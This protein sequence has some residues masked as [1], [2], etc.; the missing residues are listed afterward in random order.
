MFSHADSIRRIRCGYLLLAPVFVV[1]VFVGQRVWVARRP[2]GPSHRIK[3]VV[4]YASDK[5]RA[6]LGPVGE[7]VSEPQAWRW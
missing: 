3:G 7:P 2:V 4:L 6:I 1:F 5:E